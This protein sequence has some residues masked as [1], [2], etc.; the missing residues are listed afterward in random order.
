MKL[1][2]LDLSKN[3]LTS[4][5][6]RRFYNSSRL[7]NLFIS[8]NK[9]RSLTPAMLEDFEQLEY[10]DLRMSREWSVEC[11]IEVVMFYNWA[12]Q[13]IASGNLS[14]VGWNRGNDYYC[15][16]LGRHE[17]HSF[18]EYHEK[19]DLVPIPGDTLDGRKIFSQVRIS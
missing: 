16:D 13:K 12:E 4:W 17:R 19:H 18:R 6:E 3:G 1:E 9:F 2:N 5:T 10:L 11:S 14:L 7:R 15:E 8:N